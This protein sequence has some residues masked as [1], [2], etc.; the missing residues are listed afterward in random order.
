MQIKHVKQELRKCYHTETNREVEKEKISQ[1]EANQIGKEYLETKGFNNMKETYF[2]KIGNIVTI[3][4]AFEDN[5]VKLNESGIIVY[6]DLI[7]VKVA[8]D[9]GE[10]IGL[11]TTGYLNNHY[12]RKM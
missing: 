12:E 5:T 3:N 10:V 9:N 4:Y 8:L 1:E 7:K 2:M 11:E 6:P